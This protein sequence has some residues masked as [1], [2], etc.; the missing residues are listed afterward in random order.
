MCE[1]WSF[2]MRDWWLRVFRVVGRLEA[3]MVGFDGLQVNRFD[4]DSLEGDMF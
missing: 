2:V 1:C 4:G 3:G